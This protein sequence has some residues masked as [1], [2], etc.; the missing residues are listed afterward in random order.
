LKAHFGTLITLEQFLRL[1][2]LLAVFEVENIRWIVLNGWKARLAL[3]IAVMPHFSSGVALDNV[4]KK[5]R[6]SVYE[7]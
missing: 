4:L 1:F 5:Y 3:A 7:Q 2:T 6:Q